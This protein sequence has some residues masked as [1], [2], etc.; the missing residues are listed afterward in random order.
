[1]HYKLYKTLFLELDAIDNGV[2]QA[3]DLKYYIHTDLASRVSFFNPSWNAP[4]TDKN[5]EH[6]QFKKAMKVCEQEFFN[7]LYGQVMVLMPARKLVEQAW[8]QRA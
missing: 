2:N 7:Q 3:D 1:V 5:M 8:E 4:R 6:A